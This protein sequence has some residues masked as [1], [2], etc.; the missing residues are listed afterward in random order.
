[1]WYTNLLRRSETREMSE[2][3]ETREIRTESR[4][5]VDEVETRRVSEV[6]WA[7]ANRKW[8]VARWLQRRQK[9]DGAATAIVALARQCRGR[10]IGRGPEHKNV[11]RRSPAQGGVDNSL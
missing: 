2:V 6:S 10:Q 3:D 11:V 4:E 7:V 9:L 5:N 8:V 1:M